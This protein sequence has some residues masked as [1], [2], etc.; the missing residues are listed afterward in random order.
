MTESRAQ[1]ETHKFNFYML[2]LAACVLA[3]VTD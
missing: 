1:T 2:F 3:I